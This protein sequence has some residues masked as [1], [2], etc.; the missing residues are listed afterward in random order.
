MARPGRPEQTIINGLKGHQRTSRERLESV[1][2]ITYILK[3]IHERSFLVQSLLYQ[4]KLRYITCKREQL[5]S[6]GKRNLSI[7]PS[8]KK[9]NHASSRVCLHALSKNNFQ[10]DGVLLVKKNR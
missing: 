4:E 2:Y 5:L 1:R 10:T 3:R 8:R 9:K 6:S 7:Q